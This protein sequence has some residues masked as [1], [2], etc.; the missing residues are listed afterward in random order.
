M[1]KKFK[2]DDKDFLSHKRDWKNFEQN[3]KSSA[4]NILFSSK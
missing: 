1:F 3:N 4:L 2:H